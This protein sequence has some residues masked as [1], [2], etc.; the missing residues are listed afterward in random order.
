MYVMYKCLICQTEFIL[1]KDQLLH[2]EAEGR[3]L[4]CPFGHNNIIKADKYEGIRDCMKHD[5]YKRENGKVKQRG[6]GSG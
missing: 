2:M 6:W 5:S 3:Y 1:L 4:A